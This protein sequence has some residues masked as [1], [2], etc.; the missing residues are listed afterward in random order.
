MTCRMKVYAIKMS[1]DAQRIVKM[2]ERNLSAAV[3]S[4]NYQAVMAT[5]N[6]RFRNDVQED[7]SPV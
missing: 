5:E 2:V 1:K 7:G 4:V 3:P 6:P